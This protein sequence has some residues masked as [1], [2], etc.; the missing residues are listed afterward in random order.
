MRR[1][2]IRLLALVFF[3][4]GGVLTP[5]IADAYTIC[6]TYRDG[7]RICDFYNSDN[8]WIGSISA[9]CGP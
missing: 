3:C 6:N 8:E 5:L 7:C 1:A 9:G 4:L 2:R